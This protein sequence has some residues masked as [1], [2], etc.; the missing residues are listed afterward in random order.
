MTYDLVQGK[1][2]EIKSEFQDH[3]CSHV[4]NE[5]EGIAE[6]QQ[7]EIEDYYSQNIRDE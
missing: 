1:A 3:S 7:N 4:E 6:K 2:T 5:V